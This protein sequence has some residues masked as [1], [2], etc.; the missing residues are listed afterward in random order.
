VE[1]I[2]YVQA[3]TP[4]EYVGKL[5]HNVE[6]TLPHVSHIN[7]AA[8]GECKFSPRLCIWLGGQRS[9]VRKPVL[10]ANFIIITV[11]TTSKQACCLL[12]ACFLLSLQFYPEDGGDLFHRN[13][14]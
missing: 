6:S 7:I 4:I 9:D 10:T 13:V 5:K 8:A 1:E 2:I 14:G 3:D 11:N 12:H